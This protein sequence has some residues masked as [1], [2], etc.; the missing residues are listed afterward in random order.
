MIQVIPTYFKRNEEWVLEISETSNWWYAIQMSWERRQ[1]LKDNPE[2]IE[3]D[4]WYIID[5]IKKKTQHL[6]DKKNEDQIY[7]EEHEWYDD[8]W[9]STISI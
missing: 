9:S 3:K 8:C 5:Q 2:L 6:L 4:Y 7:Q 1:E